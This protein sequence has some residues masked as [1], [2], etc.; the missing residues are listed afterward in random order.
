[1][2]KAQKKNKKGECIRRPGEI[3]QKASVMSEAFSHGNVT[4]NIPGSPFG[5]ATTLDNAKQ[6]FKAAWEGF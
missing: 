2:E 3:F 5:S 6:Q 4:V 1:M